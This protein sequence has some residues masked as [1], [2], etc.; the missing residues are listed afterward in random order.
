MGFVSFLVH[1]Y[2]KVYSISRLI[3][4]GSVSAGNIRLEVHPAKRRVKILIKKGKLSTNSFV[5]LGMNLNAEPKNFEVYHQAHHVSLM[6]RKEL[7]SDDITNTLVFNIP[8]LAES[9][10]SKDLRQYPSGHG[11]RRLKYDEQRRHQHLLLGV[12]ES[13]N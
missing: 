3:L 5:G 10:T 11:L 13:W 1:L 9:S 7:A 6:A 4:P 8:F 2:D 12:E